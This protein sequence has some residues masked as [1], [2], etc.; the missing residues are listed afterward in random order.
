MIITDL[1]GTFYKVGGGLV[2]KNL[3]A[4]EYFKEN[5]GLFTIASGRVPSAMGY[6]IEIF[7]TLTNVP[8]ILCNGAYLYDFNRGERIAEIEVNYEKAIEISRAVHK[9]VPDVIVRVS[10]GGIEYRLKDGD[11]FYY[12]GG[13]CKI[14]GENAPILKNWTRVSFDGN[15]DNTELVRE[16]FEDEYK[17]YFSF[18]KACPEI[19]EFQDKYATKGQALDRLRAYIKEAKIADSE[20]KIYALGDFE[21]DLDLLAHADVSACPENAIDAVK[22]SAQIR[23]CHCNDGTTADLISKIEAGEA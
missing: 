18:M 9:K 15:K 8:A 2:E 12:E 13:V 5:G 16:H 4:I 19:Y 20:L 10:Y 17:E 22:R 3:K 11:D 21:N 14:I 7:K 6:D 1:D 23:L